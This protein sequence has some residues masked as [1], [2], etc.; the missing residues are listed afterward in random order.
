MEEGEHLRVEDEGRTKE[1]KRGGFGN[2][3]LPTSRL[4]IETDEEGRGKFQDT[5][6]LSSFPLPSRMTLLDTA[7]R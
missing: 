1:G 5:L 4:G 2:A 3:F 7:R 6:L